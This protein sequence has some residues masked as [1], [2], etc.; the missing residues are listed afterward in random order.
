[1][2]TRKEQLIQNILACQGML[3]GTIV[4]I[5]SR[6][7]KKGCRCERGEYHGVS[8]YLSYK[9]G[10]RTKMV[11]IPGSLVKDVENRVALFKRYWDLGLKLSL[12]NLK[13][14]KNKGKERR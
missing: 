11:Y 7:G 2:A 10:G 14:F 12:M 8:H 6:C 1:M 3:H 13:E 4:R 5:N 9:E